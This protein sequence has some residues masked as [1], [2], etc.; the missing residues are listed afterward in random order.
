MKGCLVFLLIV[1]SFGRLLAGESATAIA[2]ITAGFVTAITVTS[3]SSGSVPELTIKGSAG[4]WSRVESAT[5]VNGPWTTWTNMMVGP[6]GAVL[7]DLSPDS[8]TRFY[9]SVESRDPA[10]PLAQPVLSGS[11]PV[12]L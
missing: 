1:A 10:A 3:G 12:R 5:N 8:S 2:T 4:S 11:R 7:V 6:E 9:R